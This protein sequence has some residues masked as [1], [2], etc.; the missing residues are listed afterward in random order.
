MVLIVHFDKRGRVNLDFHVK[1]KK[2]FEGKTRDN[3]KISRQ[4]KV[5]KRKQKN[6]RIREEKQ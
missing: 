3:V 6:K 1:F 2:S 4:L 5:A